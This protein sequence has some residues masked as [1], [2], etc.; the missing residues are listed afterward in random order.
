MAN[1]T[2]YLADDN[3]LFRQSMTKT[4]P[5]GDLG[6]ELVGSAPDGNAAWSDI[7]DLIPDVVLLD[8]RMPGMSGLEV[9]AAIRESGL[10]SI[11]IIITGYNDFSYARKGIQLGVFDFILKP[12]DEDELRS[13]LKRAAVKIGE[14]RRSEEKSRAT[15][16]EAARGSQAEA[17]R[18]EDALHFQRRIDRLIIQTANGYDES[19]RELQELL[20][21]R[22]HFTSYSLV[23][24]DFT[25]PDAVSL[26]T[27]E[28]WSSI[29]QRFLDRGISAP[30]LKML[31]LWEKGTYIAVFL[32]TDIRTVKDYALEVI[33]AATELQ[34]L[35]EEAGIGCYACVSEEHSDFSDFGS[36]MEELEYARDNRFFIENRKVI[37]HASIA[38]HSTPKDYEIMR[39]TE[40]FY[41]TLRSHP[42]D[43]MSSL[44]VVID[45]IRDNSGYDVVYVKGLFSHIG[46][47]MSVIL[48]ENGI[49]EE[50]VKS[51]RDVAQETDALS[52]LPEAFAWLTEYARN[53]MRIRT[54]AGTAS[55]SAT[56][57]RIMD[58]L[59]SRYSENIGLQ[60]AAE[61]LGI[62]EGYLCRVLKNDTG[63]TFINLLNKIRVREATKLL[64]QGDLKVY[65]VADKVGYGNYAYFYQQ[66][67]K[68]TG[69]APTDYQ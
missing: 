59:N 39:A 6:Y 20:K 45:A 33:K 28:E 12:V 25:D 18:Q 19:A 3:E 40:A 10:P 44:D 32:H 2:V 48:S 1:Y 23:S 9:A 27:A 37:H 56:T 38:R 66:F 41:E 4:F 7:E 31:H 26:H 64:K 8:I 17:F 34:R 29:E 14:R 43:V 30:E 53:F 15:A 57:R 65:E 63:E 42:E 11:P 52:S 47:M 5:W 50:G 36:A 49:R 60:S 67:R 61:S 35:N 46:M 13:A 22:Y 62:S 58:Y 24:V 68:I 51:I 16:S 55:Y 69:S 54:T 21:Q